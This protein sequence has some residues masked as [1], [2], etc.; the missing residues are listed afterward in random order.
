M[1]LKDLYVANSAW[2]S[3]TPLT[4][5]SYSPLYGEATINHTFYDLPEQV[6]TAWVIC[7]HNNFIIVRCNNGTIQNH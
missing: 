5:Q 6:Q 4:V 7:F 1:T 2:D 3:K